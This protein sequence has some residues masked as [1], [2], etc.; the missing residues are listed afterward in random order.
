M[1]EKEVKITV[2]SKPDYY[3]L[4]FTKNTDTVYVAWTKTNDQTVS[5][6]I[7]A[8]TGTFTITNYL[9][10]ASTATASSSGYL[11]G[12]KIVRMKDTIL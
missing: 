5:V 2:D 10:T 7:P 11:L 4:V 12:N 6:N 8:S 1:G 3:L 9:G